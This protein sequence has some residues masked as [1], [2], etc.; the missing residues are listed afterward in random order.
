MCNIQV[1][2]SG[3]LLL[4]HTII[5]GFTG[6]VASASTWRGGVMVYCVG[7]YTHVTCTIDVELL[8]T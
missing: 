3:L 8:S 2:I 1:M 4:T 7:F 6:V 5:V